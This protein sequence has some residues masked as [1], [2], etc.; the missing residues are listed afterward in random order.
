MYGWTSSNRLQALRAKTGVSWRRDSASKLCHQGPAWIF[1]LPASPTGLDFT[2][3]HMCE[4]IPSHKSL[5]T[6]DTRAHPLYVI[7][8]CSV[9]LGKPDDKPIYAMVKDRVVGCDLRL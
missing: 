8:S 2:K 5:Y 7:Y 1:R 9:S 6:H 4:P 3:S